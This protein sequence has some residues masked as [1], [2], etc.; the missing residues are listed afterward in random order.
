MSKSKL[1]RPEERTLPAL[2]VSSSWGL[3]FRV[4]LGYRMRIRR[5]FLGLHKYF[6]YFSGISCCRKQVTILGTSSHCWRGFTERMILKGNVVCVLAMA[7]LLW[8]QSLVW[9]ICICIIFN[10]HEYLLFVLILRPRSRWGRLHE[11]FWRPS[12]CIDIAK[13]HHTELTTFC[14]RTVCL[15]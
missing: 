10:G 6:W 1:F 2:F 15:N 5:T 13:L 4:F 9:S 3:Q 11:S 12:Q 14:N 7:T 8:P